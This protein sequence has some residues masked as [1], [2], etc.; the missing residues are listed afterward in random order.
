MN[1]SS[2]SV[3]SYVLIGI[4][5]R[6]SI[7]PFYFLAP[8]VLFTT[9]I[10]TL[11]S[12][13]EKPYPRPLYTASLMKFFRQI[14]NLLTHLDFFLVWMAGILFIAGCTPLSYLYYILIDL[15]HSKDPFYDSS[16]LQIAALAFGIVFS[17]PAG[18][19]SDKY[20]RKRVIYIT[21][22]MFVLLYMCVFWA[23]SVFHI[24]IIAA[25]YGITN[26]AASAAKYAL[27]MDVLP[28][29]GKG[30]GT[31]MAV[32]NVGFSLG[33]MLGNSILSEVLEITGKT[34]K[35]GHYSRKGY[36]IFFIASAILIVISVILISLVNE[37][38]L[39]K[40][41]EESYN[42]EGQKNSE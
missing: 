34:G 13:D 24:W 41:T 14:L 33:G 29:M 40:K 12:T 28:D 22:V 30:A 27:A 20:G 4:I 42:T 8:I 11:L 7:S 26:P 1:S 19:F 15:G 9:T 25:G 16:I 31:D 39:K 36:I 38:K 17:I 32:L 5:L 6:S 23:D 3:S 35:Q 37:P 10:S 2:I 18:R 21:G